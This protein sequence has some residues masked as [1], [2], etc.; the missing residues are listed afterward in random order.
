V[1]GRLNPDVAVVADADR[2]RGVQRAR[3]IGADVA[4][5]DD[6]F[7]H[8]R[9]GRMADWVLVAAEQWG[10]GMRVLPVGPLR[11]PATSLRRADL[12]IV[13]RKSAP[14]E[15]AEE[16]ADQLVGYLRNRANVVVCHLAPYA[17]VDAVTAHREPLSWLNERDVTAVAAIGAPDAFFAQLAAQGA[18]LDPKPFPD[19]YAFD[20][21]DVARI[22]RSGER[23]SGVICTLK[24]AVKLA[25][26]WPRAG[27]TLWYVSQRAVVE[28]GSAALDTS[29]GAI[30]AARAGASSTA[31]S[32]GSS[33]SGHGDRSS[34]AD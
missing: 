2:V 33:L 7:Q 28:R 23:R 29:L 18:N 13:T 34:T 8:R 17:L 25:P 15:V 20:A 26:L 5:L 27:P 12:L 32:S 4:I 3:E 1:H 9:V 10:D 6:A 14:R 31:G 21:R 16:V 11:E 24:D 30:L 22:A 19:H